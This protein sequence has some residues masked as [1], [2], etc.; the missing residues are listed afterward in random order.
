MGFESKIEWTRHTWNPFQG[1]RKISEGCANC[2]M[3]ADKRRY[4]QDPAKVIRS[5]DATFRKPLIWH[6]EVTSETPLADR[7]VFTA[8]W[9]DWF[10]EENDAHRAEAWE[11][12]RQTPG[13]VYQILTKRADRIAE[14]LPDDWGNGFPNVWLGTTVENNKNLERVAELLKNPAAL[15]FL[16][17]EPL[18]EHVVFDDAWLRQTTTFHLSADIRGVLESRKPISFLQG[19]DGTYLTD[20]DARKILWEM[21]GAG[22]RVI[23]G[24]NCPTFDKRAGCPGHED[25]KIGWVIVGGE[26][27]PNARL[28]NVDWIRS[29]VAQCKAASVPV[30]VK[31]LGSYAVSENDYDDSRNIDRGTPCALG[32]LLTKNKKGGDPAEWPENLRVRQMPVRFTGIV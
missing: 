17:C 21:Y 13:L 15:H 23:P 25:P 6:R 14:C 24:G 26:S 20:T 19:E 18:L 7:L 8:S 9:S 32:T 30:F 2:Y 5:K 1:C 12:I 16:S 4:G 27:G 11:I 10:I 22:H 28:C 29:I 3:Y 31:Q